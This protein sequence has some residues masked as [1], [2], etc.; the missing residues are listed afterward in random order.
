MSNNIQDWLTFHY[1]ILWELHSAKLIPKSMSF[2][3]LF[4]LRSHDLLA[5]LLNT[6]F[7]VP[8]GIKVPQKGRNFCLALDVTKNP[9]EQQAKVFLLLLT[10]QIGQFLCPTSDVNW[11]FLYF[12]MKIHKNHVWDFDL[13]LHVICIVSN[14]IIFAPID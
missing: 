11:L 6:V 4:I 14:F 7:Y 13:E 2:F 1:Q 9:L 3:F 10:R 8:M 5:F 12:G